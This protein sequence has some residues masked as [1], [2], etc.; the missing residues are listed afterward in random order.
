[1]GSPETSVSDSVTTSGRL[2]LIETALIV[3]VLS[4]AREDAIDLIG[5]LLRFRFLVSSLLSLMSLLVFSL[6]YRFF[7]FL[8]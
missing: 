6:F 5:N 7:A 3:V 1:M 2:L 8:Y 4:I